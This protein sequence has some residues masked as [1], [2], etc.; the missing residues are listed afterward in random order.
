MSVTMKDYSEK[1][2][3]HRM[4]MNSEIELTDSEGTSFAGI[5]R[6]LSG[7]GMQLFV[8]RAFSEGAELHTLLPS[9]NDQFPPFET[10]CRVLRCEPDGEGYLLGV[11]I[12]QVKR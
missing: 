11:E 7:T 6:D 9:T 1:R 3:F 5:C 12:L 2:D 10:A 8:E 4:R